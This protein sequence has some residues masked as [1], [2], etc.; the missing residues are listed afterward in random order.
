VP[1]LSRAHGSVKDYGRP[2]SGLLQGSS[3]ILQRPES[4]ITP[5][6]AEVVCLHKIASAEKDSVLWLLWKK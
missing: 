6:A 5:A 3:G 2:G 1:K 4:C